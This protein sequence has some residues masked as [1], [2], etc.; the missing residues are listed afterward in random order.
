MSKT[1]PDEVKELK[2]AEPISTRFVPPG[3]ADTH[4]TCALPFDNVKGML[5]DKPLRRPPRTRPE[6]DLTNDQLKRIAA[7]NPPPSD[8]YTHDEDRPF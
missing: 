1:I 6:R 8:W 7:V 4:A 5:S 2:A 3:K